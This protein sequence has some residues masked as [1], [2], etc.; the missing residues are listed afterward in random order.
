MF[1]LLHKV[2]LRLRL[3]IALCSVSKHNSHFASFRGSGVV[4]LPRRF[5]IPSIGVPP[6]R[7]VFMSKNL[8]DSPR[9]VF[10]R[11]SGNPSGLAPSLE[12]LR[13]LSRPL[14]KIRPAFAFGGHLVLSP[15]YFNLTDGPSNKGYPCPLACVALV[16]PPPQNN[17]NRP[18]GL[19]G[20]PTPGAPNAPASKS[21]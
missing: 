11:A 14:S 3:S 13:L 20:K 19:Q 17:R 16:L 18:K 5:A 12:T 7:A 2:A 8:P 9:E 15:L 1:G 21:R 10:L 4:A 6:M